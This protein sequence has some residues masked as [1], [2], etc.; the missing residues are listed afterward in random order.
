MFRRQKSIDSGELRQRPGMRPHGQHQQEQQQQPAGTTLQ[1]NP[2][3]VF[4]GQ[5]VFA[6]SK[7]V[8]VLKHHGKH[9]KDVAAI[10][11]TPFV[12][13]IKDALDSI[14]RTQDRL[15]DTEFVVDHWVL[16]AIADMAPWHSPPTSLEFATRTA[17]VATERQIQ[18]EHA[19]E[20]GDNVSSLPSIAESTGLYEDSPGQINADSAVTAAKSTG[21]CAAYAMLVK[22]APAMKESLFSTIRL[23]IEYQLATQTRMEQAMYFKNPRK[24]LGAF[25]GSI[26]DPFTRSDYTQHNLHS[27]LC[28]K[29]LLEI[30]EATESI[31]GDIRDKR[32][33]EQ[34]RLQGHPYGNQQAEESQFE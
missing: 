13:A 32:Q 30:Q 10:D 33:Q 27:I 28:F 31:A 4:P 11:E 7:L 17:R 3:D 14:V 25:A 1:D 2:F 20:D 22:E 15:G 6:L 9:R 19:P 8:S 18:N 34:Q 16:Q 23:G 29:T 21:L 24:I 5:A 26:H 12:D